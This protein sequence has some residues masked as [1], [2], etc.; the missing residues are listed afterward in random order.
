MKN[1]AINFQFG[2]C[3]AGASS[4]LLCW[5]IKHPTRLIE[6]RFLIARVEVS[7]TNKHSK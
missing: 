6:M 2:F 4:T 3:G 1:L 7:Y 5:N